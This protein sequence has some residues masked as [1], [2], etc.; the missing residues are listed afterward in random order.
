MKICDYSPVNEWDQPFNH[1]TTTMFYFGLKFEK[2][3]SLLLMRL[4][5]AIIQLRYKRKEIHIEG[6]KE[7]SRYVFGFQGRNHRQ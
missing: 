7:G 1:I 4:K 3:I 6:A 2:N 5:I